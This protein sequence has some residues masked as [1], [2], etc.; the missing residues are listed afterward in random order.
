[1]AEGDVGNFDIAWIKLARPVPASAAIAEV[2]PDSKVADLIENMPVTLV[3]SGIT[4]TN[5]S[6]AGTKRNTTTVFNR[7]V[8]TGFQDRIAVCFR[9]N[10]K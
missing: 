3:G 2:L 9:T 5:N 4:G 7:F 10:T 1:M 6:N 8:E